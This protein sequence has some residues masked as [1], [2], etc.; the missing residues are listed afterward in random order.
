M[1][2]DDC[3]GRA[4]ISGS[5]ES[6][7]EREFSGNLGGPNVS[8]PNSKNN[9]PR[10]SLSANSIKV[11]LYS[12]EDLGRNNEDERIER[13]DDGGSG[14]GSESG[15]GYREV[16]N[17]ETMPPGATRLPNGKLKCDICGMIC[18]GPN[19]L[20]VHKR[21]HTGERPFQCNQCGASFTQKGNL[22]R[23]IKLHSG[24]KP[25][26]CPF[27]SYAC[28]RRDAL[29]GHLRTHAV[30]SPTIGKPYKCSFCG[31]S[32]KQQNTL[33]EH[34]ERC[35]GYLQSLESQPTNSAHNLGEEMR[36]LEFVPDSL[37]QPSSDKMAFIDRLANSVTKRKRSTP[38]KFV[39]QKH[40]RLN[41][42]DAPYDLTAGLDKGEDVQAGDLE[43]PH[44]ASL[45]EYTAG[46]GG[47]LSD[48]IRPLHLPP[49]HPSFFKE[50][51]PSLSSPHTSVALGPRLDCT[52]TGVGLGAVVVGGREAAEG[53][54]DLPAGRSH[55][56]SPSNGFQDSTDTESM[57]D[58]PC[59]STAPVPTL[60]SNNGHQ[61]L[62]SSKHIAR[63]PPTS[64]HRSRERRS[65]SRAKDRELEREDGGHPAFPP[66]ASA[67]TS[68]SPTAPSSTSREAFRVVDAE[69][70]AVRSFRCEHCRVLFLDHVMF[71]IHM[72]CHGF[73]QPFE[74]NICGYRSKD[75]YE[76]SSHIVRGEH[77]ID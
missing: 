47:G 30:S 48:A 10:R 2:V 14:Q 51:R 66:P 34:H 18:I 28:R 71:T 43:E 29:T 37:L 19:V 65:P 23:H 56:P 60:P 64:H 35:H 76:F 13:I 68:S 16:M 58:E 22:L 46:N 74:C 8:T 50:L 44:F 6:S 12:D 4:Y 70:R 72:G 15:G 57:P 49:P 11:E 1:D 77:I 25:F 54:E 53:H 9:S 32:Y 31:R 59:N 3:N 21:S 42:A 5:G 67:P 38:Q 33:E 55:A 26:K 17:P 45:A 39:G 36:E 20:M 24:E 63:P 73:R 40:M 61:L 52:G 75:R 69:G 27:C 41:I 7:L 62:H